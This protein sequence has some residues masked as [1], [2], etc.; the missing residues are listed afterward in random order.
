MNTSTERCLFANL[1]EIKKS[2]EKINQRIDCHRHITIPE[3]APIP[4]T[5]CVDSSNPNTLH[6]ISMLQN[7]LNFY[8]RKV[9]EMKANEQAILKDKTELREQHKRELNEMCLEIHELKSKMRDKYFGGCSVKRYENLLELEKQHQPLCL[10][11]EELQRRN[12]NQSQHICELTKTNHEKDAKISELQ[13]MI[14]ILKYCTNKKEDC[15]DVV[16]GRGH[17]EELKK[18]HRKYYAL[19]NTIEKSKEY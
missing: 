15:S 14:E 10:E 16:L 17:F 11:I 5:I 12:K 18:T 4:Q 9:D 13:E 1:T 19:L 2:I 8:I 7:N 6:T 3:P